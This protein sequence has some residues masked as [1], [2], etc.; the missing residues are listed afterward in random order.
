[1]TI[2]V[3]D[4][5]EVS[6]TFRKTQ[7][8]PV[9]NQIAEEFTGDRPIAMS[10]L[11]TKVENRILEGLKGLSHATDIGEFKA[12]LPSIHAPGLNVMYGDARGNIG[13]WA[14]AKLYRMPDSLSTKFILDGSSGQEEPLHFLDFSQNPSAVNPPWRYAYPATNQPESVA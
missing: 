13:W 1:R 9:M 4:G 10:W 14:T 11:Y 2:K 12:A 5:E 8:G 3:R 7:H 6:F